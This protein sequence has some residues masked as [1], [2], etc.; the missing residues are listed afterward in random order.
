MKYFIDCEFDGR[1]GQLVSMAIVSETGKS[2]Y[3]V[4]ACKALQDEWVAENVLP[5]LYAMPISDPYPCIIG[6]PKNVLPMALEEFFKADTSP[7]VIA[8]WPDDIKYLCEAMITG[9]GAMIDVPGMKFSVKRVDAY[10]TTLK[11]AVRHNAWWDAMALR[12]YFQIQKEAT[13]ALKE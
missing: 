3:V 12:H 10:P 5:V 7:H 11:G 2:M 6:A 1:G 8:D 9:P 13:N 4:M